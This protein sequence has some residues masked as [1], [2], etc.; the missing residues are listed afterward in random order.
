MK[1]N[2]RLAMQN[3]IDEVRSAIP[4]DATEA[5]LCADSKSCTGCSLKL[6]EFLDV[7]LDDWQYKLDQNEI[8]NFGDIQKLVK[9]SKKIFNVLKIN[10]L[11]QSD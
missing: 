10:G 5:D 1:P 2:T 4:F 3:V 7:E 11:V 9:S 8:P 6:I